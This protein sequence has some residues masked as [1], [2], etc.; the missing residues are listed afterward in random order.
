MSLFDN[1]IHHWKLDESTGTRADS[2]GNN[3]LT[4]NNTVGSTTGVLDGAAH[5]IKANQEYLTGSQISLTGDWSIS[6]WF[7]AD[8]I[9]GTANFGHG[10]IRSM[11]GEQD[12]D[13][14]IGVNNGADSVYCANY[15]PTRDGLAKYRR[16]N[17][18]PNI[19]AGNTYHLVITYE[20]LTDTLLFYLNG[21]VQTTEADQNFTQ[22]TGW[23]TEMSIGR[24]FANADYYWDGWIDNVSVWDGRIL[25]NQEV[26]RLYNSGNGLAYE[27]FADS[28]QPALFFGCAF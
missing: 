26:A 18:T 8:S 11:S 3:D 13:F 14:H 22:A 5:F 28:E 17:V 23:G 2:H 4:D 15:T 24:T 21:V 7:R 27:N 6:L 19:V 12:G 20:R 1:L 10:L 9:G 16:P 25:T